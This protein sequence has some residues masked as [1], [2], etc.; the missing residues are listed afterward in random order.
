HCRVD[1]DAVVAAATGAV[2]L[3]PHDDP[4][5]V[6]QIELLRWLAV[7]ATAAALAT[8][9]DVAPPGPI[10]WIDAPAT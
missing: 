1:G 8:L 9:A 2:P 10:P 5:R 7:R 4:R 6:A 3:A